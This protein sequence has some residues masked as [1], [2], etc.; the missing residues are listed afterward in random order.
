MSLTKKDKNIVTFYGLLIISTLMNFV[1][2]IAIQTIGGIL[3]FVTFIATYIL[4]AKFDKDSMHYAHCAYIIK[5][6]WIFSLMFTV[7]IILSVATADHSAIMSIVNQINAGAIPTETATIG[8][9]KKFG[10][11]NIILFLIIFL[12]MIVYLLYR[13]GKGI[14]IILKNKPTMNLEGWL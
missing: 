2:S 14:N 3:F 5:T 4:R 12:P 1:P 6:V 7:G 10:L 8:S 13:F 11:D 9:I